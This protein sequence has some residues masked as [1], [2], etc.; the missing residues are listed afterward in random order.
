[1]KMSAK[2]RPREKTWA[3]KPRTKN[4]PKEGVSG[5]D[6]PRTSR[7][8]RISR[9]KTSVMAVKILE[10]KQACRRGHLR[11][12]GKLRSEE[13]W[14]NFRFLLRGTFRRVSCGIP[15][16]ER[17]PKSLQGVRVFWDPGQVKTEIPVTEYI[18]L[19]GRSTPDIPLSAA[20]LKSPA[21][22]S[23]G[24]RLRAHTTHLQNRT[25]RNIQ[26]WKNNVRVFIQSW[27]W[28][29]P[30]LWRKKL[31]FSQNDFEHF[32]A[33]D[34]QT[35]VLV[36]TAEVWISAPDTQTPI[37]LGFLGIHSWIWFSAGRQIFSVIFLRYLSWK[38]GS[39]HQLR[40]KTFCQRTD[41]V[42]FKGF[43]FFKQGPFA[44]KNGRFA[45]SFSP[46]KYRT[47]ISENCL[48]NGQL[49]LSK[50]PLQEHFWI[51]PGQF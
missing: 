40:V 5:T 25:G 32:S 50:A 44:C 36:S 51:G 22:L 8:A 13:L 43:F 20:E 14:L 19:A 35:A 41:P 47:F 27:R 42:Q 49:C 46:L 38:L 34:S 33:V 37:F 3:S 11:P 30:K 26:E 12:E 17:V 23:A 9:P 18:D 28:D 45:S 4:Q 48:E 31:S 21:S 39:Q 24:S 1:M 10:K 16:E 6:V 2:S 7:G 15:R 29:P